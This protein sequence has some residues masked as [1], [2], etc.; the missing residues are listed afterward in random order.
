MWNKDNAFVKMWNVIYP[1]LVYYAVSNVVMYLAM[2]ALGV[3]EN[4]YVAFYTMLQ[5]I[6]T[7]VAIPI[8]LGYYHKDKLMF[9]VFQQRMGEAF[10]HKTTVE[11][12]K[13]A[14]LTFVGG[15]LAG[16]VLNNIIGA[17]G[18][19]KVSSGYQ[20]V[21]IHFFAG[22]VL[23]EI[24]GVGIL[25][26]VVEELLYRGVVYA[27]LAD[28]IGIGKAAV[29]SALIFGGLHF[30][31]VQFLYAFGMGL[32]LVYF[33]EKTHSLA[34]AILG[35]IGANLVTVLRVEYGILDWMES[36][37]VLFWGTTIVLAVVCVVII[38]GIRKSSNGN[39]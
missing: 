38:L 1:I 12:V 9:T 4:T 18:L 15:A 16:I 17:T 10:K 26:P 39:M 23:F 29:I 21:T 24:I 5:T 22:N 8:I 32:L 28:W 33:F 11:K 25:V 19:T 31:M 14:V 7:A 34:G 13:N 20:E 36:S 3:T 2:L 35:H 37:D 6:A 30:N 27:R